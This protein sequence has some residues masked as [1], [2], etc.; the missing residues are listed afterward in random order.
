MQSTPRILCALPLLFV[1]A[2][3]AEAQDRAP[4]KLPVVLPE[5][6]D[7]VR[8]AR[9]VGS[10]EPLQEVSVVPRVT[11]YLSTVEVEVGDVLAKGAAIAT[12]SAPELEA[13]HRMAVARELEARAGVTS[14][15]AGVADAQAM[16]VDR[17]EAV[18]VK[19]G[20]IE[21]RVADLEVNVAEARVTE[22]ELA[23]KRALFERDAATAEDVEE[24][25]GRMA[26]ALARTSAA[27]A[28]IRIAKAEVAAAGAR[29]R[30]AQ[31]GVD[32]AKAVVAAAGAGVQT[33]AAE[34][35]R[36]EILIGFTRLTCPFEEGVVTRRMLHPGAHVQADES[37][38]CT[39]MDVSRVRVVLAVPERH[40]AD[41]RAGLPV[42]LTF[43]TDGVAP[44]ESSIT[45]TSGALD[46]R[47]RTLRVE[48][49]L[50]NPE[51]HL[52]PGMFCR[53]EV[54]V[55]QSKGALTLPASAIRTDVDDDGRRRN[56]V[57]VLKNGVATHTPV[58]LGL[59]DG[60]LVEVLSGLAGSE[61]VVSGNVGGLSDGDA[62]VPANKVGR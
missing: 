41:M 50:P 56:F 29:L 17:Q 39:V 3:G 33:A 62:V 25:E 12:I 60:V 27:K 57:W 44:V 54:L 4:R 48:V 2:T 42:V 19:E 35:E 47:T 23:R 24:A 58:Q 32:T 21:Q 28:A 61:Q 5:R 8:R 30:A 13:E 6:V 14:A 37:V 40:A 52:L 18:H 53:A 16:V 20:A 34:V 22:L 7:L 59:D 51:R 55:R 26:V 43:D 38:V 49:E 9:L 31:A 11:G 45:R 36:A 15:E 46:I 1:F 10:V